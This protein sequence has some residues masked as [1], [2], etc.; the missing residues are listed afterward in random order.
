MSKIVIGIIIII[1]AGAAGAVGY[2]RGQ[3]NSSMVASITVSPNPTISEQPTPQEDRLEEQATSTFVP[4]TQPTSHWVQGITTTVP[5][6]VSATPQPTPTQQ[7]QEDHNEDFAIEFFDTPSQVHSGDSFIVNWRIKGSNGTFGKTTL[8]VTYNV[9]SEK[10]GSSSTVNSK[11]NQSFSFTIPEAFSSQ[12]KYGG[13][14]GTV[15]VVV[16]AE[17]DTR[18][19]S[20]M[21]DIQLLE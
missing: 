7:P 5:N 18:S 21:R 4:T 2:Y 3:R 15:H 20:A 8:Q 9:S 6:E 19:V 16:T 11:N 17:S 13:P 10:E 14:S 1:I 12:L